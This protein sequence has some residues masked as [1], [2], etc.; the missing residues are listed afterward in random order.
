VKTIDAN[1]TRRALAAV[2][3]DKL[4]SHNIDAALVGGAVVSIYTNE[5]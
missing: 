3:I 1:T 5:K 2:V 4:A